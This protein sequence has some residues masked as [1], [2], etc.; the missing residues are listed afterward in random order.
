[1][2]FPIT[3]AF[4]LMNLPVIKAVTLVGVNYISTYDNIISMI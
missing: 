2:S 1:M 3:H 4:V